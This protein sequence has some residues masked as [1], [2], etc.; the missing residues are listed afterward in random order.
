MATLQI[1]FHCGERT[2]GKYCNDCTTAQGRRDVDKANSEAWE[3]NEKKGFKN[4]SK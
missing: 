2:K 3:D 1:C 4:P